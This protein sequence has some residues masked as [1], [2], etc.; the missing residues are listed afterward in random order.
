V[1]VNR[2]WKSPT[3]RDTEDWVP[4]RELKNQEEWS[5]GLVNPTTTFIIIP[6]PDRNRLPCNTRGI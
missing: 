1:V 3:V 6:I 2:I 5:Y 4:N